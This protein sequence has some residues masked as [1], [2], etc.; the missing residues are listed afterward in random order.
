MGASGLIH[1]SC[2]ILRQ[3]IA[4]PD[5]KKGARKRQKSG[6]CQ[7]ARPYIIKR[8]GIQLFT[9]G[10]QRGG[11]KKV[12]LARKFSKKKGKKR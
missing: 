4:H 8:E 10:N 3:G 9:R 6:R 5:P 11:G 7:L 1:R 12:S 2:K